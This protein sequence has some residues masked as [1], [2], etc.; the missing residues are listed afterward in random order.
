[1]LSEKYVQD[2]AVLEALFKRIYS[3]SKKEHPE[4]SGCSFFD[5]LK[6]F[7]VLLLQ[8]HIMRATFH[9]TG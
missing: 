6:M 8:Y 7:L 2:F 3:E 5:S 4:L 9:N 1:M